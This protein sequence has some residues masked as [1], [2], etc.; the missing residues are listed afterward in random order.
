MVLTMN[1]MSWRS[2]ATATAKRKRIRQRRSRSIGARVVRGLLVALAAVCTIVVLVAVA[3]ITM[4][5]LPESA[6]VAH[7]N[8]DPGSTLR[9]YLSQPEVRTALLAIGGNLVLFMPL[10]VL[11]PVISRHLRGLLRTTLAIGLLSLIVETLQWG[12]IV[13][14]AFDIDDV[15]LNTAGACLA[16]LVVGRRI[17][18]SI[19][20]PVDD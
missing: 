10:G 11:L 12:L 3:Y 5:P 2:A 6:Q 20:P 19:H 4:T 15:L 1:L 14:R 18:R 13:G 7:S 8:T 16:Y 9:L 17:T